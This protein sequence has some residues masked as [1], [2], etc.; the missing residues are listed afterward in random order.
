MLLG[1]CL[2]NQPVLELVQGGECDFSAST[3][4]AD[5]GTKAF[6]GS[7][8]LIQTLP[9]LDGEPELFGYRRNNFRVH[10]R[11][12]LRKPAVDLKELQKNSKS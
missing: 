3:P 11:P 8:F 2:L 9:G 5:F 10:F 1:N 6:G 7:S 4:L 12:V